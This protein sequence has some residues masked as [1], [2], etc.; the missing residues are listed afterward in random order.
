MIDIFFFGKK[1]MTGVKL[2]SQKAG[3]KWEKNL[4]SFKFTSR[5]PKMLQEAFSF[6]GNS[7]F[8]CFSHISWTLK[9]SA[10]S[11]SSQNPRGVVIKIKKLGKILPAISK[12]HP[13]VYLQAVVKAKGAYIVGFNG[14]SRDSGFFQGKIG[15]LLTRGFNGIHSKA[16]IPQT[17][18]TGHSKLPRLA[19]NAASIQLAPEQEKDVNDSRKKENFV[20]A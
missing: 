14:I 11:H 15:F 6:V 9:I 4:F 18:P 7:I 1:L 16:S 13:S 12:A 5:L 17:P 10:G 3:K 8:S 20:S 19:V 2:G